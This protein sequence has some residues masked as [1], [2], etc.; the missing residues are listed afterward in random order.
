MRFEFLDHAA[1]IKFKAYGSTLDEA[2]GHAVLAMASYISGGADIAEKREKRISISGDDYESLL[3]KLFDE[4]LFLLD[5]EGFITSKA[6]IK[7]KGFRLRAD[8]LGDAAKGRELNH[9]KAPTYYDMHIKQT[10]N[11]KW[12]VQAVLD[13]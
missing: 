1:D 4:L 2:F 11:S 7:I 9:I 5:T 10:G 12:E 13:V 3:Y 8:L 6:K